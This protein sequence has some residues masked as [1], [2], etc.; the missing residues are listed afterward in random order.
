MG[1][2]TD[3]Y[4]STTDAMNKIASASKQ[5]TWEEAEKLLPFNPVAQASFSIHK[6]EKKLTPYQ[7]LRKAMGMKS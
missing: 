6:K 7:A 5:L 3:F 2:N 4:R 1:F